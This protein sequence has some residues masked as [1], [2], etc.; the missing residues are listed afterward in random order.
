[1]HWGE[2]MELRSSKSQ[3]PLSDNNPVLP[4]R[5]GVV[6]FLVFHVL[7]VKMEKACLVGRQGR[8]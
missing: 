4:G 7:H 2:G 5:K 8:L 6:W 3:M 1:M